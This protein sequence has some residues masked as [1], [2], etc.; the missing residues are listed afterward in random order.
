VQRPLAA[1]RQRAMP[2]H[3]NRPAAKSRLAVKSRPAVKNRPAVK[4]RLAAIRAA[5]R[6]AICSA[7][8]T[9]CSSAIGAGRLAAKSPLAVKSRPVIR[10][11]RPTAVAGGREVVRCGTCSTTSSV[12]AGAASPLAVSLPPAVRRPAVAAVAVV[13]LPSLPR[14]RNPPRHPLKKRLRFLRRPNP[15][16]PPRCCEAGASTVLATT[17]FARRAT[18]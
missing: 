18:D 12:A 15:I 17:W 2:V 9:D 16:P 8:S 11:A 14:R 1:N 4:S 7:A 13:R 6:N 10:A 3:P 5:E